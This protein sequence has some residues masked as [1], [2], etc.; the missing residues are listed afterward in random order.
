MALIKCKECG[1]EVST[2][3]KACPKCG[4]KVKKPTSTLTWVFVAVLS[5]GMLNA[6][7]TET[8]ATQAEKAAL[9]SETP[10]QKSARE[11]AEAEKKE[12]ES[13]Q[14]IVAASTAKAIKSAMREPA[15]LVFDSLR[16]SDDAKT[17]CAEYRARNGFGG[18]SIEHV[19]VAGGKTLQTAKAWNKHC[20][21]PMRDMKWAA[22]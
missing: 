9:A 11:K 3:A 10:E 6:V 13:R 12:K 2:T 5:L 20:L 1:N 21:G 16:I 17:L 14:Y 19:V 15:S 4:A 8:P 7:M 22:R 18:M